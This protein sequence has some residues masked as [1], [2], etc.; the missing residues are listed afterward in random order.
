MLLALI[1]ASIG[2]K[3]AVGLFDLLCSMLTRPQPQQ[4]QYYQEEP[5]QLVDYELEQRYREVE[6]ELEEVRLQMEKVK[7]TLLE[8]AARQYLPGK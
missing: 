5:P 2:W 1:G 7:L 8:S 4:E 6:H 3:V